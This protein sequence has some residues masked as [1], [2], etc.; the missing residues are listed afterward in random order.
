LNTYASTKEAT[1][2]SSQGGEEDTRG[3]EASQHEA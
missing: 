3:I 2:Q 1:K